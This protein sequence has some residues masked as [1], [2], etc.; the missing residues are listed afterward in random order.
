MINR[1]CRLLASTPCRA[2]ASILLCALVVA[3]A[4]AQPVTAPP[5]PTVVIPGSGAASRPASGPATVP[6]INRPQAPVTALKTAAVLTPPMVASVNKFIADSVTRLAKDDDTD[7]AAISRNDLI[8]GSVDNPG[9]VSV[10]YLTAYMT[11]LA[12]ALQPVMATG[13]IRAKVNAAI[14]AARVAENA[15]TAG[16]PASWLQPIAAAGL[17]DKSDAVAIWGMKTAA[18]VMNSMPGVPNPKLLG[19][20]LDAVQKHNLNGAITDEAYNALR[21]ANNPQVIDTLI[22]LYKVRVDAYANGVPPDPYSDRK[23]S[24]LLTAAV[25]MWA[26]LNAA[27]KT[28]VM[29]LIANILEAGAAQYASGKHPPEVMEQLKTLLI[30]TA[31]AVVIVAGSTNNKDLDAKAQ[32]AIR[33][34]NAKPQDVPEIEKPVVDGVRQAFPQPPAI[35]NA[36]PKP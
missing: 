18:G 33:I 30:D 2:A 20:I 19:Q 12:R 4:I 10:A 3:Q 9:P 15:Q 32:P 6:T 13:S 23:A 1:R 21:D 34:S 35:G 36:N 17:A 27:Q 11:S 14:V 22:K 24:G 25:G 7:A 16:V 29:N 26:K 28:Q 31:K 5:A 8:A